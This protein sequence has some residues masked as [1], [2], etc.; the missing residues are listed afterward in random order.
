M[1]F[2]P[3]AVENQDIVHDKFL[4]ESTSTGTYRYI[5]N[6]KDFAANKVECVDFLVKQALSLGLT[7]SRICFHGDD[8]SI[9]HFMLVYHSVHHLVRKHVHKDKSEYLI[10]VSGSLSIRTYDKAGEILNNTFLLSTSETNEANS[11]CFIPA[12]TTHDVI[13][14]TDSC[15]LEFTSGPFTHLSTSY[16]N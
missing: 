15:F 3:L 13:M 2:N 6:S 4:C 1:Q 10:L 9:L 8:A 14:H 12:G 11:F 7:Q 16:L 5:A